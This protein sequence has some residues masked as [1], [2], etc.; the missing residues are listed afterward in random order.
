MD[1]IQTCLHTVGC[2]HSN[3][4][5]FEHLNIRRRSGTPMYDQMD[6]KVART[7]SILDT[8]A[9]SD[10]AKEKDRQVE[11]HQRDAEAMKDLQ[12]EVVSLRWVLHDALQQT[13]WDVLGVREQVM[14]HTRKLYLDF[15]I[16]VEVGP[17]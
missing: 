2:K 11:K 12:C 14:E 13:M 5:V 6:V 15:V 3:A 7:S 9:T 10:F 17:V 1:F 4:E 16:F 8:E